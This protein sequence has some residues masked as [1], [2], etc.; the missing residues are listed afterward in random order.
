[1]MIRNKY[2]LR[3]EKKRLRQREIELK[4]KITSD[5]H[6]LKGTLSPNNLVGGGQSKHNGIPGNDEDSLMVHIFSYAA[7]ILGRKLG[8]KAEEKLADFLSKKSGG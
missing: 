2:E 3:Q 7:S 4:N 5:W 8:E 1:M 6:E